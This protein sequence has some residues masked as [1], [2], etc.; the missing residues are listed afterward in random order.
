[1]AQ[2][3]HSPDPTHL[4]VGAG[5]A[6]AQDNRPREYANHD[7]G[8]WQSS[9]PA[10]PT[11]ATAGTPGSFTPATSTIPN[12]LA[13]MTGVSAVPATAW[14]TGQYVALEDGSDAHWSG[15]AWAEGRAA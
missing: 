7:R 14:T 13:D 15:T 3:T 9:A 2:L 1:M 12:T 11:G 10:A 6:D 8:G 4:D 5:T